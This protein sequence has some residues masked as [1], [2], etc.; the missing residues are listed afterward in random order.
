MAIDNDTS[1]E[2]TGAQVK[3]L[4]QKIRNKADNNTFVGASSS[5]AGSKGLVPAPAI[6]DDTKFLKGDGTWATAGGGSSNTVTYIATDL[7]QM[8]YTAA[9]QDAQTKGIGNILNNLMFPNQ[10]FVFL[11]EDGT[12]IVPANEICEKFGQGYSIKLKCMFQQF[13]G[14]NVPPSGEKYNGTVIAADPF[15]STTFPTVLSFMHDNAASLYRS[16]GGTFVA[17]ASSSAIG[18]DSKTYAVFRTQ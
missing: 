18:T 16:Q 11:T 8:R 4:A 12:E 2:L 17:A 14:L 9:M 15:S 6:G 3:D 7:L 5:V 10:G 1:Y 13:G